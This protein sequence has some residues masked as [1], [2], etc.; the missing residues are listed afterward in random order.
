[1]IPTIAFLESAER[2]FAVQYPPVFKTW[3]SSGGSIQISADSLQAARIDFICDLERLRNVNRQVGEEEWGAYEQAL[4]GTRHPKDSDRLWGGI[5]P[6]ATDSDA[7][8][9]GF[10]VER[11]ES[12]RVLVWSVHTIVHEYPSLASFFEAVR[13]WADQARTTGLGM[14]GSSDKWNAKNA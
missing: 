5:L 12:E 8:V 13:S 3:C 1:M 10:D 11:P 9:F 14:D 6:F 2:R 4:A 7:D